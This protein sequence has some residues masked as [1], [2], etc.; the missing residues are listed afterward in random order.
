[1][2]SQLPATLRVGDRRSSHRA[3]PRAVVA[4]AI[5]V[6]QD[7]ARLRAFALTDD[8]AILQFVHDARGAAVAETQAALQQRDTRLLFAADDFD[9]LLDDLLVL[10]NTAFVA[11]AGHGFGKLLVDF[12]LVTRLAL[13]GDEVHRALDFV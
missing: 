9:A 10:V 8:A 6:D 7:F 3:L 12:R 4:F 13:L 2:F 5:E 11:E 1:M